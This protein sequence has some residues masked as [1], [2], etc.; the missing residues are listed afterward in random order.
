MR[1]A[2]PA[3]D[4]SWRQAAQARGAEAVAGRPV[5]TPA[6]PSAISGLSDRVPLPPLSTVNVGLSSCRE[7]TMLAKFGRPGDLTTDCSDPSPAMAKRMKTSSVGPF[8]V[9][10]LDYSVESFRRF[11]P[12]F[13]TLCPT[14]TVR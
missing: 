4:I 10:G 2:R 14:F 8:N 13:R 9:T 6:A 3:E 5:E 12:M 11:L 7:L 1:A